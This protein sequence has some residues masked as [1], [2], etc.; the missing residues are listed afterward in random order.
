M[1][2][3]FNKPPNKGGNAKAVAPRKLPTGN[4]PIAKKGT[5]AKVKPAK[6][7]TYDA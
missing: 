2:P 5:A 3:R 7:K 6:S 1:P 4:S